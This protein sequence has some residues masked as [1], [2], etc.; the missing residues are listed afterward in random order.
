MKK[1][2]MILFCG[3][4]IIVGCCEI[5]EKLDQ[6]ITQVINQNNII[7]TV[8]IDAG[9]GGIDVG[10]IGIDGS[11]EKSINLS[12]S[13]CLYD[14]LMTT[15]I[16]ASLV[17]NGDYELYSTG[18]KRNKSDLYNRLDYINSIPNSTLISIH[19][20]HFENQ[21]EWGTQIWYSPNDSQSQIIADNI[22]K[23]IKSNLQPN[24]KRNN[25]PSDDSYYILYKATVPS[26][27]IECGFVSNEEENKKLQDIEYQKDM[28]YSILAGIC[29]EI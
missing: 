14:F 22:L 29:E 13:F 11:L 7:P 9:H 12:I 20:N 2:L 8:I 5:Q 21:A 17:R 16:N 3:I 25:K 23:E 1:A 4:L 6:K 10:T 28:S 27:M 18:E 24:N 19:Q 26:I 15:G